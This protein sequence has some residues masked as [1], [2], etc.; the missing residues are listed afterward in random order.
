MPAAASSRPRWNMWQSARTSAALSGEL[1][2]RTAGRAAEP[3]FA[4][5]VLL[6]SLL[7]GKL[8]SILLQFL[9]YIPFSIPTSQI[10]FSMQYPSLSKDLSTRPHPTKNQGCCLVIRVVD[11]GKLQRRDGARERSRPLLLWERRGSGKRASHSTQTRWGDPLR[12]LLDL[13]F[14]PFA[15]LALSDQQ[16]VPCLE[17]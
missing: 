5:R 13:C 8:V 7:S 12:C 1:T 3:S 15:E 6:F 16:I 14:N 17:I 9:Q 11:V 4:N 10:E 2:R